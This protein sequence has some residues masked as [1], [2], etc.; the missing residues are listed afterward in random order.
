M[1]APKKNVVGAWLLHHDQKLL[2]SKTTAF[3]NIAL[4]GRAA[5]LLSCV[6]VDGNSDDRSDAVSDSWQL[7][8]GTRKGWPD[9]ARE[10]WSGVEIPAEIFS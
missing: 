9:A 8:C 2:N 3:E 5:R 10:G 1:G 7:D 4:A 6:D